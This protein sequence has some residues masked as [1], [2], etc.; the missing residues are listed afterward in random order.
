MNIANGRRRVGI[1]YPVEIDAHCYFV[2]SRFARAEVEAQLTVR[3]V[4]ILYKGVRIA[5]HLRMS[6]NRKHTT[7]PEH[8]P[9]LAFCL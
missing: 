8:M 9:V 6:G 7:N 4:E 5:F 2:P 3:G 1:D